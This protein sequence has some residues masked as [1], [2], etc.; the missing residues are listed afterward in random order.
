MIRILQIVPNMQA[1]G[2]ETLIMNIYRNIDRSKVQFDFLVHYTGNYFYDEEIRN[3]GGKIYKLSVRDD[4]NFGKY[5]KDLKK[6][7][8]EH[9]EYKIIHGHMES[10]GQF[11]FK[12]AK[13]NNIPVRIAHSHNSSTEDTIKGKMKKILLK[14]FHVYATDYFAC[15]QQA[16]EFM[17]GKKK[18]TVLKNAII[19][20]NFIYR[21]KERKR[22]RKALNIENKIVIGHAG[23]FCDQKNHKFLVDIFKRIA[24]REEKAVLLLIGD[25]ENLEK[26]KKQVEEYGLEERVIFL[27][28]RKDIA[29]IYQAMDCFVFPSLFEGLGIVAIEAQCSGLPVVASDVVPQE[30]A[31]TGKFYYMSLK[32]SAENWAKKILEVSNLERKAEIDR[33]RD[34]GYDVKDVALYLQEFYMKKYL[35]IQES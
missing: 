13:E 10:L 25:G 14:R 35:N 1:G 20:N 17:F 19:I 28:V 26:V 4:N 32:D 31:V 15:S 23:R 8:E 22:L 18:F 6:F 34:A 7:F 3:L 2:L 27:G 30:A 9:P 5:L 16:G 24:E 21:D 33:I 11:Y 29:S 12:I